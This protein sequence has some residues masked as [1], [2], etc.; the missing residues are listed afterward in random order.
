L[1]FFCTPISFAQHLESSSVL[2]IHSYE[3]TFDWTRKLHQG[4]ED[5][6]LGAQEPVSIYVER[7]DAKRLTTIGEWRFFVDYLESKYSNVEPSAVIVS[8]GAALSMM[9]DEGIELFPDVPIL[10]SGISTTELQIFDLS[11]DDRQ[12]TGGHPRVVGGVLENIDVS[13]VLELGLRLWPDRTT[14][15]V[16]TDA[17]PIGEGNRSVLRSIEPVFDGRLSFEYMVPSTVDEMR[18]LV[19]DLPEDAIL[20]FNHFIFTD[21]DGFLPFNW[22]IPEVVR[23][24]AVPVLG[25]HDFMITYGAAAGYVTDG[26][27]QGTTVA[28]QALRIIR[29]EPVGPIAESPN[30]TMVREPELLR[31]D[32]QMSTLPSNSVILEHEA[33]FIESNPEILVVT[34]G[35][36]LFLSVII[37]LLIIQ[38]NQRQ[39][40]FLRT[41]SLN[42]QLEESLGEKKVL[43]RE[44]HHRTKN[45]LQVL[46]SLVSLQLIDNSSNN[47]K[48]VLENLRGRIQAI[49]L[50]HHQL[51]HNDSI[52]AIDLYAYIGGLV[53]HIRELIDPHEASTQQESQIV[54]DASGDS[55]R[56][57]MD[58][59]VPL[60]L[61]VN[62][63]VTNSLRHGGND[64]G[65]PNVRI[66]I[67]QEK[68][69]TLKLVVR[70]DGPGFPAGIA[71]GP[72]LGVKLIEGLADQIGGSV[73]F[74]NAAGSMTTLFVPF[75][76]GT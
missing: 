18:R 66:G 19:S 24:S 68:E 3:S 74:E 14:V 54:V 46:E 15:H 16:L 67:S 45:N 25:T 40:A 30:T 39:R 29:G 43:M 28:R 21:S 53:S 60:G 71:E 72:G 47:S 12:T 17:T 1:L 48:T 35:I 42:A 52:A 70:D 4:I 69:D 38:S 59:A 23:T 64:T 33:G 63:S 61:I 50:V 26:F 36:I 41:A 55:P 76:G 7:L 31:F 2:V 37:G 62:E 65:P 58:V 44:V 75:M 9:L 27:K 5:V 32:A 11:L 56:V 13:E 51:Y 49:A 6:L 57:S 73:A 20:L 8:D 10:F 34:G 22:I